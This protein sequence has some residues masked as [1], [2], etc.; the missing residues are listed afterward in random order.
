MIGCFRHM[1]RWQ[2]IADR[3]I[4]MRYLGADFDQIVVAF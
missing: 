4:L 2:P 1:R 3:Q